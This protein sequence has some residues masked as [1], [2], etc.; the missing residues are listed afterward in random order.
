MNQRILARLRI[1]TE[2]EW[3]AG[4]ALS[5]PAFALALSWYWSM[6]LFL[7]LAFSLIVSPQKP[8]RIPRALYPMLFLFLITAVAVMFSETAFASIVVRDLG[9]S[10]L[11][12]AAFLFS[13]K[14]SIQ[15][16]LAGVLT[17]GL[18]L[19]IVAVVKGLLLQWGY[20]LASILTSCDPYPRG[21]NLCI[22][23]NNTALLWL[24]TVVAGFLMGP[25]A[26]GYFPMLTGSFA[27]SR[28]FLLLMVVP[29]AVWVVFGGKRV[30]LK[31]IVLM[32]ILFS[33][34]A[35]LSDESS[36]EQI[37]AGDRVPV[38]V[39]VPFNVERPER[40]LNLSETPSSRPELILGT[41]NDGA[42]GFSSRVSLFT[43][44]L[45]S[46]SLGPQGFSYHEKF[47]CEFGECTEFVYPHSP[48]LSLW[49]MGG[50][51]GL[52]LV[53]LFYSL[54]IWHLAK[55]RAPWHLTVLVLAL[56]FSLL[57][58]DTVFSLPLVVAALLASMSLRNARSSWSA[59]E[60]G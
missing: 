25:W 39:G 18:T 38:V 60:G 29:L 10:I 37:R 46:V 34:I 28:R 21:M 27:G 43:L 19:A 42:L 16:F 33:S 48:I 17:I 36:L 59:G 40:E 23:G 49:L 32:T 12:F 41:L 1:I 47:S 50:L 53:I 7:P 24:L 11:L 13:G 55:Q 35:I 2:P 52:V 30:L 15:G 58:G 4:L 26:S 56:P 14:R 20:A 9:I 31:A 45:E 22:N 44:G 54:P 8:R 5:S 51:G 57:S 3:S 6:V